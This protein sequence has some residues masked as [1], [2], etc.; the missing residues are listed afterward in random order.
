VFLVV[1]L[2][3]GGAAGVSNVYRLMMGRR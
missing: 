2:F 1:G 3:L